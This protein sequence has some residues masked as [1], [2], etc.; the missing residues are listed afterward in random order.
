MIFSSE[1]RQEATVLNKDYSK[2]HFTRLSRRPQKV[3]V[4]FICPPTVYASLMLSLWTQLIIEPQR[5]D[6]ATVNVKH[7][8]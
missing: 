6:S 2:L 8:V 3:H 4:G 1:T 5:F 7:L